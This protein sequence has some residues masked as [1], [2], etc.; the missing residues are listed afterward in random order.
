MPNGRC[1]LQWENATFLGFSADT[2]ITLSVPELIL[3]TETCCPA[4]SH[5]GENVKCVSHHQG[6]LMPGVC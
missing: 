2:D 3:K 1:K 4:S 5:Q 6:S